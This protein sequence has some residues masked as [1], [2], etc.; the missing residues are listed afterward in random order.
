MVVFPPT[1]F[2]WSGINVR[3]R[4]FPHPSAASQLTPSP[5]GK[6]REKTVR[7]CG[8]AFVDKAKPRNNLE[9]P[10]ESLAFP[11]GEGGAKGAG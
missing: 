11:F 8:T 7:M 6:A 4:G 3:V 9:S 5:E 10:L 1:P 2:T